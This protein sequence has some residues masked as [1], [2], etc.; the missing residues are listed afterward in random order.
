MAEK[1]ET[2]HPILFKHIPC[3]KSLA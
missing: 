3:K 1:L 2:R